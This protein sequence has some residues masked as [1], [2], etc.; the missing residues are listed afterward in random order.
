MALT[1]HSRYTE[2]MRTRLVMADQRPVRRAKKSK[3]TLIATQGKPLSKT[4]VDAFLH[5]ALHRPTK[6]RGAKEVWDKEWDEL[7]KDVTGND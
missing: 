4:L 6:L 5:D 3:K 2:G 7:L 1:P